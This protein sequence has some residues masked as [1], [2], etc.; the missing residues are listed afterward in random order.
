MPSRQSTGGA[1]GAAAKG[2]PAI[3]LEPGEE[4]RRGAGARGRAPRRRYRVR[5]RRFRRRA[6]RSRSPAS[7]DAQ[8]PALQAR[9][10]GAELSHSVIALARCSR[11][12]A[13]RQPAVRVRRLARPARRHAASDRRSWRAARAG[14]S[15]STAD[16]SR[17]A[18]RDSPPTGSGSGGPDPR[19]RLIAIEYRPQPAAKKQ[20]AGRGA[21][22]MTAIAPKTCIVVL[23]GPS[24]RRDTGP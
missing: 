2:M 10:C 6:A 20:P 8:R 5:A 14:C 12:R 3:G 11:Q 17:A 9:Q 4:S 21:S 24:L 13:R 7:L 23:R 1:L 19:H 22:L 15:S 16:G 18:R